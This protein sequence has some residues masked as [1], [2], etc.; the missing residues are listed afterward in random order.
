[1]ADISQLEAALVK[2]DAAGNAD[3][4]RLLAAEIRKMRSAPAETP[5][6]EGGFRGSALGGFIQG[7]RDVLDAGAQMLS[8]AMPE[9]ARNAIN[10]ANNFIADKTGL[11]SRLPEGGIDEQI[12]QNEQEYQ[13]ARQASGREGF[14]AARMTGNIASTLPLASVKGLQL[15]KGK[16]L[17]DAGNI[18]KATA[19]GGIVGAAQPVTEGEFLP[20]KLQQ[21]GSGAAFGAASAPIGAALGR[22]ISPQTNPEVQSLLKQGVTPTP[23]QILGGAM[24]RGEDKLMSVPLLGDA[25][26]GGRKRAQ[27]ELNRA[28]YARALEGTGVDAKSLSVGRDGISAIKDT[29]GKA[30]DDLL[31]KL[32]FKPD[33]QFTAELGNLRQMATN[34]AP[35]EARKFESILGEHLSKVSPNGS[36]TGETFKI[37]ESSLA[38]EIKKFSGATD[39]YQ[40][41]L[42]DALKETLNVFRQGLTR[43]NPQFADELGKLNKNYANYAI[44]RKAGSAAGDQS[45]GFTPSQLAA[46]VRGSDKSAGKGGVATGKALMQDLSDAGVNVLNS[47]Y[48]DSGSIGRALMAGGLGAGVFSNPA[49][50]GAGAAALPYTPSGQKIMAA[51]LTKRPE[52]AKAL[53]LNAQKFAPLVGASLAQPLSQ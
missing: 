22:M 32:S 52:V 6:S 21:I 40:R 8:Q 20:E 28:A 37:L 9:G 44:L 41:E 53:G 38:N 42:G 2:A 49:L 30:Y 19:A 51:L 25:I 11:V 13:Q 39:A 46:A 34:L 26:T 29:L 47:K 50:L 43:S 10:S 48:P 35:T 16:G 33:Q 18:A 7:G 1:M 3:D 27:E 15:A 14:D 36:M 12:A 23:G 4:A 24:Q 5:K 45:R 17:F 31:P